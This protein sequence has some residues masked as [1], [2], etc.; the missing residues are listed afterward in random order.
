MV[1]VV[2]VETAARSLGSVWMRDPGPTK[3][4][5]VWK[6]VFCRKPTGTTG[7]L[8]EAPGGWGRPFWGA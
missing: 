1:C 8:T 3:S 5:H 7:L 2:R 6:R 4:P